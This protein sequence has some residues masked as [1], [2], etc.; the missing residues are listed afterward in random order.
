MNMST[1]CLSRTYREHKERKHDDYSQNGDNAGKK[2]FWGED[3]KN[4]YV[5]DT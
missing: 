1:R 3:H 2:I 5:V 4:T